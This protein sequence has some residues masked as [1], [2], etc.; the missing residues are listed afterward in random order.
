MR[1][2]I[3]QIPN[4]RLSFSGECW[5]NLFRNPVLVKGFPIP[6]RPE[7]NTGLQ[8][9]L[10]IMSTLAQADRTTLY[11]GKLYIKAFSVIL[12]PTKCVGDFVF[13]HML[14]N[15]NGSRISY[16]DSRIVNL[17]GLYPEGLNIADI[18]QKRHVLGWCS[19]AV[20]HT[21]EPPP[22]N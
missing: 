21:G 17:P 19:H 18:S 11:D 12:V 22:D 4:P 6:Y 3:E 2:R 8:I 16:S 7:R 20:D 15:S 1:F 9:P 5:H 14:F 13:W 10:S